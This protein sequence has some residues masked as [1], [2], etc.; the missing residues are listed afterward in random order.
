MNLESLVAAHH[1]LRRAFHLS[2]ILLACLSGSLFVFFVREVSIARRQINE[3]TQVVLEY[4]RS[5][6]PVM[7]EFRTKLQAFSKEHPDFAPIYIKYFGSNPPPEKQSPGRAQPV[8]N[9]GARLPPA[10]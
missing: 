8:T 5:A 3:L 2:L 1:S 7:E 10:P 9:I 4:E 6:L